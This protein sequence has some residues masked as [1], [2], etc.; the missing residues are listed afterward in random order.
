MIRM[1]FLDIESQL[2]QRLDAMRAD[3]I[4]LTQALVAFK[5]INPRFMPDPEASDIALKGDLQLHIVVDEEAGRFAGTRDLIARGFR[6]DGIIVAEPTSGESR[7]R[8][9]G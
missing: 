7:R 9:A 2:H 3:I 1:N 4:R 6:A 8:K 5:S